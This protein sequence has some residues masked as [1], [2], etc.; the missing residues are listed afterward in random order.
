M[1][2]VKSQGAWAWE[3]GQL[4]P[5]PLAMLEKTTHAGMPMDNSPMDGENSM[6]F[7]EKINGLV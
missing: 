2:W 1:F 7:Q 4:G 3:R 6:V 5:D